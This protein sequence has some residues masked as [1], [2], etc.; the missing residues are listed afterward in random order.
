MCIGSAAAPALCGIETCIASGAGG[1]CAAFTAGAITVT[2]SGR[3]D[4]EPATR[5]W[6]AD[7]SC[8]CILYRTAVRGAAINFARVGTGAVLLRSTRDAGTAVARQFVCV[9]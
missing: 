5:L 6:L 8:G 3:S 9:G 4:A 7:E 1:G 2:C